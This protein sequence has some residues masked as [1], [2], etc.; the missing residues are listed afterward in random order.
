M[1]GDPWNKGKSKMTKAVKAAFVEVLR[2]TASPTQAAKFCGVSTNIAYVA[3]A[4]DPQFRVEWDRAVEQAMD[5]L[6]GEAYRRA[7][8]RRD[9]ANRPGWPPREGRRGRGAQ[10]H[11]VQRPPDGGDAQVA[12][13]GPAREPGRTSGSRNPWGSSRRSWS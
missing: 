11:R 6:Q 9:E 12:V 8:P 7:V 13:P 2:E 4:R 3:R 10:H 1:G 5:Q